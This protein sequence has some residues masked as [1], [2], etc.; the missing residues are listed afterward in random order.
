MA[1]HDER[2]CRRPGDPFVVGDDGFDGVVDDAVDAFDHAVGLGVICRRRDVVGA[3][4]LGDVG[5]QF[6]GELRSSIGC[7]DVWH[8]VAAYPIVEE[9]GGDLL[10]RDDV[11]WDGFYPAGEAVD[12]REDVLVAVGR[13][14]GAEQVDVDVPVTSVGQL[15]SVEARADV[16]MNSGSL[17]GVAVAAPLEDVGLHSLPHVAFGDESAGCRRPWVSEAVEAVED[18]ASERLG[19]V[20]TRRVGGRF[21]PDGSLDAVVGELDPLHGGLTSELL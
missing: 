12:H 7:E 5:E 21:A 11:H 9:G 14:K 4:E 19:D 8:S 15:E 20:D 6:A 10:R 1:Q 16:S 18:G 3:D 13:R 17:A 2:Q